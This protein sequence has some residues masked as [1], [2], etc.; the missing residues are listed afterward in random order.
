MES[1]GLAVS[2]AATRIG[3]GLVFLWA[4]FD[5]LLG[6][7][8]G[9]CRDKATGA[10][11]GIMC[12]KAWL[13][14]GNPTMG[15]LSGVK[16]PFAALFNPLAGN[17]VVNVLFM[18]GLLGIGVA[19]VFG[20]GMKLGTWSGSL[21][22]IM[23]WLASF[24]IANHPFI[25]DHLIYAIAMYA[26]LYANASDYYGLGQWWKGKEFVKKNSWLE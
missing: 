11:M 15:F 21:L 17:P 4:F 1:K 12:E 16:G 22:L 19:F 26:L 7:G 5:K 20:A 6:L 13:V 14:N 2:L 23:M 9:T 18:L 3:L 8:F 24:P 25:D 10:Y